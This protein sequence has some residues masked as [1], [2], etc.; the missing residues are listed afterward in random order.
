MVTS[1]IENEN[2]LVTHSN[3]RHTFFAD[4]PEDKGGKDKAP[5][6][7]ELLE[8][9]LASCTLITIR[10]YTNHK[11]WKVGTIKISVSLKREKEN[12]LFTRTLQFEHELTEEQRQRLMQVAKACPVSKTI[13]GNAEMIVEV[14]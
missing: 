13:T 7:D 6:P 10:M 5:T 4:E 8:A 11:Q 12:N 14:L 3:G 1:S 9:A 2:Y